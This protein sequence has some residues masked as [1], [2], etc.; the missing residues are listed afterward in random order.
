MRAEEGHFGCLSAYYGRRGLSCFSENGMG[1]DS[2]GLWLWPKLSKG[3][4]IALTYQQHPVLLHTGSEILL[5]FL[6]LHPWPSGWLPGLLSCCSS[7]EDAKGPGQLTCSLVRWSPSCKPKTKWGFLILNFA[8]HQNL[9]WGSRVVL[10]SSSLLCRRWHEPLS[11]IC[12]FHS[13]PA[14]LLPSLPM[15]AL[16]CLLLPESKLCSGDSQLSLLSGRCYFRKGRQGSLWMRGTTWGQQ[17]GNSWP[18]P[19]LF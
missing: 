6:N 18:W 8:S 13:L 11:T 14:F 12:Y 17:Q 5:G 4:S 1:P 2:V 9:A 15:L 3:D 19:T 16:S 7:L 10:R